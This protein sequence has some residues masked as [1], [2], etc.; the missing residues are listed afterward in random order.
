MQQ[1]SSKELIREKSKEGAARTP[2]LESLLHLF[3]VGYSCF[4]PIQG[5]RI[6]RSGGS[7]CCST[8]DAIEDDILFDL[9]QSQPLVRVLTVQ[10]QI[11]HFE[12]I[13]LE[14]QEGH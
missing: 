1:P 2:C 6:G 5:T 7:S 14:K 10:C 11:H 8:M 9:H 4:S 3:L 13:G 12:E